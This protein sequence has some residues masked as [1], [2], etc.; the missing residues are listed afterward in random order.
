MSGVV[1]EGE[2]EGGPATVLVHCDCAMVGLCD[3]DC[4]YGCEYGWWTKSQE[5]DRGKV[6]SVPKEVRKSGEP[7]TIVTEL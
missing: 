5:R 4:E 1:G 3:D 6:D 2:G 7:L